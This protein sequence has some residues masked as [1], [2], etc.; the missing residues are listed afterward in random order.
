MEE[1]VQEGLLEDMKKKV[2]AGEL[3]SVPEMYE[4]YFYI[5]VQPSYGTFIVQ[6]AIWRDYGSD[7]RR[8]VKGNCYMDKSLADELCALWN[9]RLADM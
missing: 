7:K 2:V 9:E 3:V 6:E 1:V 8:F 5:A 4:R